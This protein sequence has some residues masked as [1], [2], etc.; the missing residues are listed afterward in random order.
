MISRTNS[1]NIN[2]DVTINEYL[3]KVIDYDGTVIDEKYMHNNEIYTLPQAPSHNG[4]VFQGWATSQQ[5]TNNQLIIDDN[6]VMIGAVYTTS[7][8]LNEFDIE[9]TIPTGLSV[10]LNLDGTKDW[11]D[12]TSDTNTT[13]IY[14]DYGEY[15]IKCNGTTIT[16]SSASGL[17]G[18][19]SNAINYYL[20]NIRL[21]T[22][23][24]ITNYAFQ[25]CY[26][27]NCVILSTT[28]NNVGQYAFQYCYSLSNLIL[29]NNITTISSGA[30]QYCYSLVC[31]IIPCSITVI[32]G[33]LLRYCY[34]LKNIAIPNSI[35]TLANYCMDTCTSLTDIVLPKSIKT[36]SSYNFDQCHSLSN[37]LFLT[38]TSAYPTY[39]FYNC[40]S[41]M[42]LD[43]THYLS[44]PSVIDSTFSGT[45]GFNEIAKIKVPFAL[46]Y[47]CITRW[48]FYEYSIIST[49]SVIVN[50]TGDNNIDIYVNNH[51]IDNTTINWGGNTIPYY[52][53]DSTNNIL[54][55]N[56]TVSGMIE[57]TTQNI[58][59]DLSLKKKITLSTDVSGLDVTFTIE[60]KTYNATAD[61]G[62]YY[63]Y[64]IGSG[65][66]IN[67]F[68]PGD[69]DHMDTS[70]TITTN[71]TNIT[72]NITRPAAAWTTF[73][74]P[75]L[76]GN[77]TMGGNTFAVS[78]TAYSSTY[79]AWKAVDSNSGTYWRSSS[80][81]DNVFYSFY[82]PKELKVTQINFTF[83]HGYNSTNIS[84][85]GSNDNSN[86]QDL[87]TTYSVND[88]KGILTV[89]LQNNES[90]KYY[91]MTILRSTTY[92]AVYN[93][94][95]TATE[96]NAAS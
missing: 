62:D 16:S 54:L 80:S 87:S 13:H 21:A 25:Y 40:T 51:L 8:G 17:F 65:A 73:T 61:N 93:I 32:N 44:V 10:T 12:G 60:N 9:L 15:T 79:A 49:G 76:N 2:N 53:Y 64:V 36:M 75:N 41:I 96:K 78:A 45:H 4:L 59:I 91:R 3:V 20:K 95:I 74:R 33:Y 48:S 43:F 46:Y 14:S 86:W 1:N 88:T 52:A 26:S 63:I 11:G 42:Y 39:S 37:I 83:I 23:T 70:G 69:N 19:S 90:Y 6:N 7:S 47:N 68:I 35:V 81:G 38:L 66:K 50:F 72:Q 27:L 34:S 22:I 56:Q 58:N 89:Q 77:G 31:I 67:Y 55:P 57:N 84:L 92:I 85:Q 94:T 28:I 24:A 30:F 5:I 71:N 82:N 29:S 18:Q